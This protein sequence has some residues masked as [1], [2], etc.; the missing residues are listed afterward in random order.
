MKNVFFHAMREFFCAKQKHPTVTSSMTVYI[1]AEDAAGFQEY[2]EE[3]FR[4][5]CAAYSNN[6]QNAKLYYSFPVVYFEKREDST[7]KVTIC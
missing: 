2:L 5:I 1:S 7:Y 6:N 4:E 3:N